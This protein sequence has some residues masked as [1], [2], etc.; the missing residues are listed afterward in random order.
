[1]HEGHANYLMNYIKQE[2]DKDY[3]P[4]LNFEEWLE[5]GLPAKHD[6]KFEYKWH[7]KE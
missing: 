1:M 4:A 6:K 3:S 7:N 2:I 5:N